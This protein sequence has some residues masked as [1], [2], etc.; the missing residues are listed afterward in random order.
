MMGLMQPNDV[1]MHLKKQ[2]GFIKIALQCGSTVVPV[3]YLI[4]MVATIG[5]F[6]EATNL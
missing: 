3:F 2:K 5:G 4:S 1:L 6:H